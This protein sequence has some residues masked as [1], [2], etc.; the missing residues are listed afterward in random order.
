MNGVRATVRVELGERGYDIL[1]GEGLIARAGELVRPLLKSGRDR[2]F[3][4]ADENVARLHAQRLVDG[5]GNLGLASLL[6]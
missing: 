6:G 1:I 2:V 5:L 3:V 4:V